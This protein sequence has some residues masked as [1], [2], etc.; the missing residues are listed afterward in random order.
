MR[1]LVTRFAIAACALGC[2]GPFGSAPLVLTEVPNR[3]SG[4]ALI[5]RGA[6]RSG[7]HVDQSAE[8]LRIRCDDGEIHVPLF[9]GPPTFAVRCV[10]PRLEDP[11]RCRAL[12]RRVLMAGDAT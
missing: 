5:V 1:A 3:P 11:A 6:E 9:P 4:V 2:S 10:D 12:V 8:G 7:C